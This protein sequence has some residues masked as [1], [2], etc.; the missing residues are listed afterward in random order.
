MLCYSRVICTARSLL[1]TRLNFFV[2]AKKCGDNGLLFVLRIQ[3]EG[4]GAPRGAIPAQALAAF[5]PACS[6]HNRAYFLKSLPCL[7]VLASSSG[8]LCIS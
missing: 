3:M 7:V 8:R 6:L 4:I 1:I 2:K 5:L